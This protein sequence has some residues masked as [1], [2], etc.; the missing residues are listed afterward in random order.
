MWYYLTPLLML[1]LAISGC[2]ESSESDVCKDVTCDNPPGNQCKDANTLLVFPAQGTCDPATGTCQY[3]AD[4]RN[5]SEGCTNGHCVGGITMSGWIMVLELNDGWV[6]PGWGSGVSAFFSEQPHFVWFPEHRL[7]LQC[8]EILS[9]GDCSLFSNCQ[10]FDRMCDPVCAL[11]EQCVYDGATGECHKFTVPRNVGVLSIEGLKVSLE[12]EADEFDRY[13][14]SDTP[15][16][17]FDPGDTVTARTSGGETDPFSLQA[18]GVAPFSVEST[19]VQ[20]AAGQASEISWTPDGSQARVQ[21]VLSSGWHYP[22]APQAAIRCDVPDADGQVVVPS[23]IVDG[24]L[25]RGSLFN[26]PSHAL[27]YT[28]TLL[29]MQ[30]GEVELTVGS[31]ANLRLFPQ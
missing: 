1:V 5:C 29:P 6:N 3:V 20:L 30:D 11:D 27:R 8:Q 21:V 2:A 31:A 14:S 22:Y 26:R 23:T 28:R 18:T 16:D 13:F 7:D 10:D 24:F 19:D 25:E 15:A 12:I 4:E 9:E 17:L